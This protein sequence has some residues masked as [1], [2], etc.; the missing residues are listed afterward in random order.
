MKYLLI[1]TAITFASCSQNSKKS[2]DSDW[3]QLFNGKDLSDWT[4]KFSGSELNDNY[5]NTFYVEDGL[6]KVSYD[7]YDEFA[8]EFGHIFYNKEKFSN[9]ILR[10]EYRFVGEQVIG[11]PGWAI[12][13]NGVMIHSQ[14]AESMEIDQDFPVSIEV[15]LLGG[16]N[17]EERPTANLCTPGTNVTL[18]NELFTTHCT[19]SSS[20][21][22]YGE[23]WV[24]AE[25]F[26]HGNRLIQHVVEGDTVLS[27]TNPVIGGGNLPENYPLPEGTPLHEGYI[28]LQAES[29]PTEFR[30]V[31]ILILPDQN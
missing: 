5:K 28:S 29:H 13:N 17:N 15:Q 25:I 16:Y 22:Y 6:L 4:I 9:Y 20:K 11:G 3:I 2:T 18:N 8:G 31:E 1:L 27:Y 7:E 24:T 21:T 26:V 19:N 14:S 23:E 30:K 12:K 10:V